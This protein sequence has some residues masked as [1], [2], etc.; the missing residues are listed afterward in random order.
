M[1]RRKRNVMACNP[2]VTIFQRGFEQRSKVEQDDEQAHNSAH[3]RVMYRQ[4]QENECGAGAEMA[5]SSKR[6]EQMLMAG[7]ML[8]AWQTGKGGGEG[9]VSP[10]SFLRS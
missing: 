7:Q 2:S 4:K 8:G 9:K 6:P 1:S 5:A 10:W 3:N